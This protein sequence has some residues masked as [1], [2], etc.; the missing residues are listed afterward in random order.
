MNV[1]SDVQGVVAAN[2]GRPGR[3]TSASSKSH[4]RVVQRDGST[5]VTETHDYG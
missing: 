5:E 1:V 3:K 2:V 4:V